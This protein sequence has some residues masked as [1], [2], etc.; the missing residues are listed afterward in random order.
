[1]G[2]PF[3]QGWLRQRNVTSVIP[4]SCESQPVRCKLPHMGKEL[5]VQTQFRANVERERKR[6]KWSRAHLSKLLQDKGLTHVYPTTVQKIEN[7]ERPARIDEATALAELFEVSVDALLGRRASP[8]HDQLYTLRVV[9]EAVHQAASQVSSIEMTLRDRV[10]E[11]AALDGF[12]HRDDVVSRCELAC[13]KLADAGQLLEAALD[14]PRGS[15]V[16]RHTLALLREAIEKESD[17]EA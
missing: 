10:R 5:P 4:P 11:L 14:Q 9:L 6:R 7:G 3:N 12:P 2:L 1:V 17:D 8:K 13:D 15:V 16:K